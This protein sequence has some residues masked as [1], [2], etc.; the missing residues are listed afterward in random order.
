MWIVSAG[1]WT[2][3]EQLE[4]ADQREQVLVACAAWSL[5]QG[6]F[7]AIGKQSIQGTLKPITGVGG[8]RLNFTSVGFWTLDKTE[9]RHWP[10]Q[11]RQDER[12]RR[13]GLAV[14][15]PTLY[16]SVAA[17]HSLC[18]CSIK[19]SFFRVWLQLWYVLFSWNHDMCFLVEFTEVCFF[20]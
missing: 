10:R 14:S 1:A 20:I 5:V 13:N 18:Y 9:Y 8:E 15:C 6:A 17:D 2:V 19:C 3:T 16:D 11:R 7:W 12:A 4:W